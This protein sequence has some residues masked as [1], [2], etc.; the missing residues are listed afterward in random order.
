M[1]RIANKNKKHR[2]D[3]GN[4]EWIDIRA[5]MSYEEAAEL[6]K[7]KGSDTEFIQATVVFA[8]VDWYLL[9]D[10]GTPIPFSKELIPQL[11]VETT[12]TIT[13]EAMAQYKLLDK[14]KVQPLKES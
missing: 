8:V 2:I 12:K 9:D 3:L 14:K 6:D 13:I 10:N 4:N 7:H 11:D 1:S 5:E